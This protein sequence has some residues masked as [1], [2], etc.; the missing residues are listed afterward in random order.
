[1][2]TATAAPAGRATS[3]SGT[4]RGFRRALVASAVVAVVFILWMELEL[5][6]PSVTEAFSDIVQ[7]I[8]PL[9]AAGAC[10][11]ASHRTP[12]GFGRAWTASLRRS[13][14]LLGAAC[15][16]W[17]LGQVVWTYFELVANTDPF[18][19]LA[20]LGFLCT[21]P[22]LVAGVLA[23][24]T[25]ASA[26]ATAR[27][28]TLLDGLLIA[29]SLLFLSWAT[30]LG[31]A[32][33]GAGSSGLEKAFAL[34][35][36]LG[37]I[38]AATIALVVLS[39]SRGRGVAHLSLIATAI[40]AL[41]VSD[42]AFAYMTQTD[43][44]SSGAL[45]NTGWL[46]GWLL[47][48]CTALRPA[49]A[50]LRRGDDEGEIPSLSRLALPYVP[51]LL[52]AVTG[53]AVQVFRGNFEPFLV[54]AGTT[55][56]LL[57]IGRQVVALIENRLL[58]ARL[59]A[60]VVQLADQELKLKDALRR[61]L[62]TLERMKATDAMKDTFLRAVSHDLRTPLTAMLGVAVTLERTKLNLPRE[63]AL[64]LVRML[65]EKTQKL[66][67]LLKDLLD[68]NRLEEGVLEPNRSM[69]D[70]RELVH[71]VVTEIDQLAGW[72]IDIEAEPIMAFIDGPK[73][74]RIIENLLLNTTR[75]TPPGTRVWVRAQARGSDLELIVEDAGPGVPAELVGTIFEA[76]RRGGAAA[77][78]PAHSRGVG[79]GLS[80]VARFA[81]LHGGHAWVDER[82]GG[83]AAFHVLLPNTVSYERGYAQVLDPL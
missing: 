54:F 7:S 64:D 30:V 33:H 58:T 47:F 37:D 63:Q 82:W 65:V 74:E 75:H 45:V 21:V 49:V 12:Y 1:M 24:P 46:V 40:L 71:R 32:Y 6:G 72:P 76:F 59:Q 11:H 52:A 51:L 77:P 3:G 36:P 55:V 79:I 35:Y 62:D 44:Y 28:R 5:G 50:E 10:F 4:Q 31:G 9:A 15:L 2:H 41:A 67:R 17:G 83:G 13:W 57:V 68:L 26:S 61:E 27:L 19:S 69:T 22:L 66:E 25:G 18:P 80:L 60:T 14:R 23:F 42:S 38:C 70:V 16:S 73:V 39:R 56:G 78:T 53:L 48:L 81:Q 29:V 43:S 20:D 8:V 34:A